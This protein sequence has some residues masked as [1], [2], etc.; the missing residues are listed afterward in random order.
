MENSYWIFET[1]KSG[2]Y[3]IEYN[4]PKSNIS[5][6]KTRILRQ[7]DMYINNRDEAVWRLQKVTP[8]ISVLDR[9]TAPFDVITPSIILYLLIGFIL[10]SIIAITIIISGLLYHFV[11]GE[12]YRSVFGENA[13]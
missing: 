3:Y 2:N 12:F 10:G 1:Q 9:P 7:R 5:A 6:E 11:K 8:I 4:I 13:S